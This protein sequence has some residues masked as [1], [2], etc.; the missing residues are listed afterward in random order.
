MPSK[1]KPF[2]LVPSAKRRLPLATDRIVK[3]YSVQV[4]TVVEHELHAEQEASYF[5]V[6]MGV[7]GTLLQ[8]RQRFQKL[9]VI[10][11]ISQNGCS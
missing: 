5:V 3:T 9:H 8:T 4:K 2:A 11:K 10:R 1:R 7:K 6:A